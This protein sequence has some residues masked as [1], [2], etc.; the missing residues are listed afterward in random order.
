MV[1]IR[2]ELW[3][4]GDGFK[5]RTLGEIFITNDGTAPAKSPRGNYSYRVMKAG[6]SPHV[7]RE[8]A[9]R[10]FPRKRLGAYDLLF[11]VLEDVFGLR[12]PKRVA[13]PVGDEA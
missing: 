11:R 10:D 6:G 2:I 12:N 3:P 7:Y 1:Y 5:K 13:E 8:G 9:V 4:K